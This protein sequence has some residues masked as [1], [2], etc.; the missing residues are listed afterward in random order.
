MGE[1]IHKPDHPFSVR[2]KSTGL[3]GDVER[4]PGILQAR[5][6]ESF[7]HWNNEITLFL[8]PVLHMT[9]VC[10][11]QLTFHVLRKS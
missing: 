7:N 6:E 10:R 5:E 8:M 11:R 2:E 3:D 4:S 9:G 1:C